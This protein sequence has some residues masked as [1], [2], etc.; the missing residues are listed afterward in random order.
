MGK[1][2]E[3]T[4]PTPESGKMSRIKILITMS[5]MKVFMSGKYFPST[6]TL[7]TYTSIF[8]LIVSFLLHFFYSPMIRNTSF[9][10]MVLMDETHKKNGVSWM[11]NFE[12]LYGVCSNSP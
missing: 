6:Q 11:C 2:N 9:E 12:E 5:L 8:W 7:F 4:T 10:W 1:F 3:I